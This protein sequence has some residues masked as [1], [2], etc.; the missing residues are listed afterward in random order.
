MKMYIKWNTDIKKIILL[1]LLAAQA[2]ALS[3]AETYL[4]VPVEEMQGIKPGIANIITMVGLVFFGFSDTML[5]VLI[6]C[7]VSSLFMGG[8]V[9][10]V[11]SLAGGIL[12]AAVMLIM[13][14]YMRK[15]F[16]L[17]GIGIAGAI[18]HNAGQIIVA[19]FIMSDLS[20]MAYLPA[21]MISGILTGC[22]MGI[23]GSFMVKVLKKL[24]LI[25]NT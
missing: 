12:N 24:N 7:I 5:I 14:K 8:P 11:F 1:A 10:F 19:C 20:I 15:L 18:A 16:S 23:V 22:L 2:I 4:P 21:L 6:R 13:L 17:V 25:E 3:A 9:Q